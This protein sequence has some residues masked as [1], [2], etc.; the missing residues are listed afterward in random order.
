MAT[1]DLTGAAI[2]AELPPPQSGIIREL[3]QRYDPQLAA[4]LLPEITIAGSSGLG[5]IAPGQD[6]ET[7]LAEIARIATL[8]PPFIIDFSPVIRFPGSR[9]YVLP[10]HPVMPFAKLQRLLQVSIRFEASPHPF[11][12]HCSLHIKGDLPPD[13]DGELLRLEPP[14]RCIID[15]IAVFQ[16]TGEV[17]A[18]E[19]SRFI[20]SG[21]Q[22][23]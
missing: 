2:V 12:P 16:R 3:R 19:V 7:V 23:D 20:L 10:V 13:L 8:I 9:V 21:P 14:K 6:S 4:G 22:K 18:V 1:I 11:L 15:N 5:P 17:S